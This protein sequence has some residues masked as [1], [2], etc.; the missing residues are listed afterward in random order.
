MIVILG[1]IDVPVA[2]LM[3]GHNRVYCYA[4][5]VQ[6]FPIRFINNSRIFF[7]LILGNSFTLLKNFHVYIN[8]LSSVSVLQRTYLLGNVNM[9]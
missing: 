4:D 1:R 9:V 6:M 8:V 5:G 3:Y 7:I 2:A